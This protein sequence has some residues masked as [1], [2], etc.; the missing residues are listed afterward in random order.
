METLQKRRARQSYREF[1]RTHPPIMGA[2]S[3]TTAS[4]PG[5]GTNA[6]PA[7]A[8]QRQRPFVQAAHHG[9]EQG[10]VFTGTQS[11]NTQTNGPNPLPATG[12]IRRITLE[13]VL[14]GGTSGTFTAGAD[15]PFNFF[16][17][18][19]L[20]EPNAAPI[21]ELSG[22]NLLMA[23]VY[24]GYVGVND[25]RNDPDYVAT[26]PNINIT[27]FIPVEL[28]PSAM[29]ALSNLSNANAFRMTLVAEATS[30]IYSANP[31]P[32]PAFTV[33]P[34]IDYWTLPNPYDQDGNPQA[35]APPFAGTI[36]LWGQIQ[37]NAIAVGNNRSALGRMG[38]QL[39]TIIMVTRISGN[40]ADT[41][42][43]NPAQ[44]RWDDINLRIESPQH[45]RKV[46]REMV[47][48]MTTRDTGVYVY[49]Y[50]FGVTRAVGGNGIS[51]LLPTVTA[52]R[53]ELSGSSSAAGTLDWLVNDI[54]SAP[55]AGVQRSSTQG[56]RYYPPSPAPGGAY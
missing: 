4:V 22:F 34:H 35:T 26:A 36:Q 29:G 9:V 25:P 55:V 32:L 49:P 27:P 20:A 18:I 1:R 28:D 7:S 56:L 52:T 8:A 42:F 37:N 45:L 23:D 11:N 3:G 44:L 12:Y 15:A 13:T 43:P 48:G 53:Y 16:N 30:N 46:M 40:R 50:S 41:P 17:L 38:N 31:S 33:T 2:A 21:L 5:T 19:R 10:N 6:A 47:I 24:G 54:S 51:S 39:R 14:S